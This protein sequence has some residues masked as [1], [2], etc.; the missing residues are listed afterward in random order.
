[1]FP[2]PSRHWQQWLASRLKW[3][4]WFALVCT[5]CLLAIACNPQPQADSPSPTPA[6][7]I[8]DRIVLG[9]TSKLRTLD[10][11]DAYDLSS[12]YLLNNLGDRLYAYPLGTQDIQPQLATALPTV[13]DDGLTYTVPLRQG[14]KFHDGTPFDAEAMAF[15]L[16]RFMEN[17]GQP[18]F[19]LGDIIDS[20]EAT[21]EYELTFS[22]KQPF[23]GFT[24][25][26]TF[27]GAC[28]VSPQ[29][30]QIGPGAFQPDT[31][32][33]TGRYRLANYGPD[34]LTLEVFEDYWG[35][36]P[37]NDGIDLQ[38]FTSEGNLYNAFRTGAIDVGYETLDPDQIRSLETMA[39]ER[40]WQVI[41]ANGN[42]VTYWTLNTQTP[43]LDNVKVR[44]ALAFLVD[45]PAL[46]DRVSPGQAEPL[47]SLIPNTFDVS[48]AVFQ[49]RYGDGKA[50]E[51][52]A[53]LAEEGYD[54]D[55]PLS[56]EVWYPSGSPVRVMLASTLKAIAE[57]E[58]GEIVQLELKSVEFTTATANIDK[59]VYQTFL[60]NWFLDFF[61]PDNYVQPFLS[62]SEG[63]P[64][65]GCVSGGS[66]AQGSFYYNDRAN[67]AIDRQRQE[68]DPQKRKAI[69]SEIQQIL[70]EE[71]PYIPLFQN[72]EYAF[73]QAG[74]EGVQLQP[75]QPFPLWEIRKTNTSDS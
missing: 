16:R 38:R 48:E 13:S 75:A 65:R 9:T 15:S 30:Y 24:A 10:P 34:S 5:C 63:S 2:K 20:V 54:A 1:M 17:G 22:L 68:R 45:R 42:S 55:N 35:E 32:V 40:G 71:V 8:G 39:P 49:T 26:L 29:H 18:S 14:V 64:L 74:I 61:D 52:K 46:I 59:G 60:T 12:G 6:P 66:Q 23:A 31:F 19:L 47:Y 21:G 51:A 37:A 70:A 53:L 36:K 7:A 41:S 25:L 62:C 73:A 56:I 3:G 11:A 50:E 72:K 57:R 4:R 28:A 58:L 33:G 69:F 43:P 67:A 27:P 44:Q